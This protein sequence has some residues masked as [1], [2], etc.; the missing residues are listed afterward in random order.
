MGTCVY[1]QMKGPLPP[2]TVPPC[3]VGGVAL[4]AGCCGFAVLAGI[5]HFPSVSLTPF[6]LPTPIVRNAQASRVLQE[7]P[8]SRRPNGAAA[9]VTVAGASPLSPVGA[10]L[11]SLQVLHFAKWAPLSSVKSRPPSPLPLCPLVQSS[12]SPLPLGVAAACPLPPGVHAHHSVKVSLVPT[13]CGLPPPPPVSRSLRNDASSATPAA[14]GTSGCSKAAPARRGN[15]PSVP[16]KRVITSKG[17]LVPKVQVVTRYGRTVAKKL[18]RDDDLSI[19]A[20]EG[21]AERYGRQR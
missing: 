19:Q 17:E 12:A 7:R 5:N 3:T 10:G 4:A 9:A 14:A 2:R 8:C 15:G 20:V 11:E 1:C 13:I 6:A 16:K 18:F 21:W